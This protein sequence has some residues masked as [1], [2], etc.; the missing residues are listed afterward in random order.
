MGL[1]MGGPQMGGMG[2]P[3]MGMP[4][5]DMYSPISHMSRGMSGGAPGPDG[6]F[7]GMYGS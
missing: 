5:G 2:G 1:Q 6:G 7:P 3:Q 4:G